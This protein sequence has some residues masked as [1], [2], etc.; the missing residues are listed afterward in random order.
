ME[1]WQHTKH[2]TL[3]FI[4][5]ESMKCDIMEGKK[6]GMDDVSHCS[7]KENETEEACNACQIS[8]K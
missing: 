2:I 4:V 8:V 5:F 7:V 6:Y 1:Y 3:V